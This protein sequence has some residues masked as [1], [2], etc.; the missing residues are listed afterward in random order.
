MKP[1]SPNIRSELEGFFAHTHAHAHD[2]DTSH[3]AART[4]QGLAERHKHIICT[5]L[6]LA[7]QGAGLTSQEISAYC[8][9]DYHQVARRISDLKRNGKVVDTGQRRASPGGRQAAVWKLV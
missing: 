8:S 5:V 4:A 1:N 2:P 9:L 7:N 3:D 6:H